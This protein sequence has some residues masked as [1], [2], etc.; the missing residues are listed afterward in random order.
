MGAYCR[1]RGALAASDLAEQVELI[2]ITPQPMST[3]EASKLWTA[4]QTNYRPSAAYHVSVVLIEGAATRS[5]LPVL[6]RGKPDPVPSRESGII[7]QPDLLPPFPTLQKVTPPDPTRRPYGRGA[8]V[9]R[10]SPGWHGRMG[11]GAFY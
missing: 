9:G 3:E 5:P 6:T 2:K 11:G 4:F 10:T 8:G 1:Q 7:S